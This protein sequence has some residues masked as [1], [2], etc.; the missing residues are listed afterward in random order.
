MRTTLGAA[1]VGCGLAFFAQAA[2]EPDVV[3]GPL[4]PVTVQ[5]L[6]ITD[7]ERIGQRIVAVGDRGYV[8]VSDDQGKSWKRAKAPAAPLLTAVDFVDDQSGLAVGHDSVILATRD[9][10]ETWTQVFAAPAEQRPLLDVLFVTAESAI[11]VGAY[12]AYYESADGGR[13]WAARKVIADDKH[14]NA[15]LDV[16]EA[17]LVILGEAGT[18]LASADAGKTWAPVT[19]PYKGSLFGG[20]IANDGAVVAFG[21]RGR[22]FRSTDRGKTWKQVDNPSV[23]SLMGGDRLPD[24]ALVV[25][26]AAGTVLVSRDNGQSFVPLASGT[27]RS[28]GKALLGGPNEVLLMGEAGA[29]SVALPSAMKRAAP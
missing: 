15:I 7:A 25:A 3:P 14:L 18:I 24:G 26:G 28:F 23:A 17:G 4:A 10:G 9:R 22:I 5:R 19:A 16:G 8:I 21:M 27:T 1:V 13:T 2:P 11:A 20:L 6:L 12:G 29:R